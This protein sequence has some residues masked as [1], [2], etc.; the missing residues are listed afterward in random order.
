MIVPSHNF[1]HLLLRYSKYLI[2]MASPCGGDIESTQ[3]NSVL[4][5][6]KAWW[7][8]EGQ[9]SWRI[10]KSASCRF[11]YLEEEDAL[12]AL[13]AFGFLYPSIRRL[14]FHVN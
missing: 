9:K 5:N 7:F 3:I 11:L 4:E 10:L 14:W 6:N 1:L 13:R 8:E 12:F 2:G